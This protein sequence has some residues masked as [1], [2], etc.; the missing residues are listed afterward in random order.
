MLP[1]PRARRVPV[2]HDIEDALPATGAGPIEGAGAAAPCRHAAFSERENMK[3]VLTAVVSVYITLFALPPGAQDLGPNIRKISDGIYVYAAREMDANVSIIQTRDG[4]VMI[5]T[6][7]TPADSRAVAEILKKLTDQPVRFIIHTEPHGDHTVGDFVFS[8]PAVVIAHAGATASMRG[9]NTE[10]R[11]KRLVSEYP[12]MREAFEGYRM[13]TPHI[14]Y[15]QKMT[16][17]VGERTIEL[18]YLKNVHS[19]ADTAIWLGKE[20]FSTS[21]DAAYRAVK[22]N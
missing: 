22:G 15:N 5:D 2:C 19:E 20:R 17:G 7:Q 12:A 8:P 16:L 21:V 3:H 14:E 18:I 10:G 6:G 13:V 1:H 4:V 9:A 11:N